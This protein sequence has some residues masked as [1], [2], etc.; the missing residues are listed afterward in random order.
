MHGCC[1]GASVV[2]VFSFYRF[3]SGMGIGGD[4]PLVG[5]LA[6]EYAN[7]RWRGA[8]I[9]A[10]FSMQGFGILAACLVGMATTYAFK[11]RACACCCAL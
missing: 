8:M 3:V 10:V 9:A 6:S 1:A 11:V 4:Y 2:A 7:K 5:C